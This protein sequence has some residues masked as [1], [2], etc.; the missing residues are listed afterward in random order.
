MKL[1]AKFYGEI[2]KA[3]DGS[4]VPDD[5]YMVFLIKDNAFWEALLYYRHICMINNCDQDQI[6]AVDR[7]TARGA[8]WREANPTRCKWPDA[9]GDKLL[10][11]NNE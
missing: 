7:V 9:K 3:K 6:D 4:I 10:D 8:I 11:L 1:D 2:R 5:E